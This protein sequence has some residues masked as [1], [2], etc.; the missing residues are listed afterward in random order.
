MKKYAKRK[1]CRALYYI[2]GYVIDFHHESV[3]VDWSFAIL[4]SVVLCTIQ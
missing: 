1:P 2:S 4:A 3:I